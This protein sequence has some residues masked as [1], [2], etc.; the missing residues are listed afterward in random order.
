MCLW[1][2]YIQMIKWNPPATWGHLAPVFVAAM[3]PQSLKICGTLF[4]MDFQWLPVAANWN[5]CYLLSHGTSPSWNK[6]KWLRTAQQVQGTENS[7]ATHASS[8][9]ASSCSSFKSLI[10][11]HQTKKA[12]HVRCVGGRGPHRSRSRIQRLSWRLYMPEHTSTFIVFKPLS[13]QTSGQTESQKTHPCLL[14]L[15]KIS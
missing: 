7:A 6:W 5:N 8:L 9:A 4:R 15:L 10:S 13:L 3:S 14:R 12:G 1:F 2:K 11:K